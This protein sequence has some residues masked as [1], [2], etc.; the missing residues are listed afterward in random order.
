MANTHTHTETGT[1]PKQ[2]PDDMYLRQVAGTHPTQPDFTFHS[3]DESTIYS[4]FRGGNA[5]LHAFKEKVNFSQKKQDLR[6]INSP[7]L[8]AGT[9]PPL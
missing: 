7:F 5:I 1:T 3:A 6:P 4:P 8:Q 2:I 9:P